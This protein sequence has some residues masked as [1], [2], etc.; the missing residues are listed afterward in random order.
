MNSILLLTRLQIAQS[1]GGAR[2]A[3]E[4]RT[5]ANGAMAG[6]A[7]IAVILLG[8]LGWLGYTAYG[9]VGGFGLAKTIYNV[10]FLACGMLTFAFSLPTVLSSF[11]GSSDINDLLPLP[12]SP[13]AIVLSKAL[14]VL[15]ASY[16]WTFLFI[17][18]PLAGWGIAAGVGMRYW[19]VYILA[20]LCAPLM[21]TAYAGTISI[22]VATIFKRVR[23]KDAITTITT[24]ISLGL[25][26]L[27]YFAVNGANLKEGVAQALGTMSSGVG[28]VVMAFPAYGFAVYALV[29]ADPLGTWLFVLLSLA[30]FA[31]FVVVA[32]VLYMRIVT[33]L[34]SG[35]GQTAAYTGNAAQE[36]TPL[37]KALFTTEVRKITRNSSVLL[38]YVVYPLVISPVMFGFMLFSDSIGELI[39]KIGDIPNVNATAAGFA[40]VAIMMFFALCAC[41][42]KIAATGISRE[43]SNWTHIKFIPVPI[44]TQILAKVLCG[45]IVNALIALV[46]MASGGFLLITRM[47]IS[48]VIVASGLVL[49]L[50]ASWL[51]A[52]VGAWTESRQPNVDWGNDGDVNAKTLK[53]GGAELRALLVGLI[54]AALPILVTPV[55]K[56]DPIVFF[57]ILSI[58]GV[59]AAVV[60]GRVLLAATAKNIEVF[61]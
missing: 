43:G 2:A 31:I 11:F 56:L 38:N 32:R 30:S 14:G 15:A 13:F 46:L 36:K 61:E 8:G 12:V 26:V 59:V 60:L 48:P 3:V 5:G 54:Y 19:V 33:Q 22:L 25:S 23:R 21:P 52:C 45:F 34:S 6:T 28:S 51:M 58:L 41:S 37:L 57:P 4:K 7:L 39:E 50:G 16:L 24:V 20:V 27:M 40:M 1:I 17:A 18:G 35:A 9:L 53:G 44:A 47:G 49:A 29:H 10:L 42:N 55:V